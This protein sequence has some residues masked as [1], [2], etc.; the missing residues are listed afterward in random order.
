MR[1]AVFWHQRLREAEQYL[2][3]IASHSESTNRED[4]IRLAETTLSTTTVSSHTVRF[5]PKYGHFCPTFR[6]KIDESFLR[7]FSLTLILLDYF[8]LLEV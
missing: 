8:P 5:Y 6:D 3:A 7:F 4:L 2:S 1:A